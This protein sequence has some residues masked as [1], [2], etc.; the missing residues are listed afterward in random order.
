[1]EYRTIHLTLGELR[2]AS[3]LLAAPEKANLKTA[4]DFRTVRSSLGCRQADKDLGKLNENGLALNIFQMVPTPSGPQPLLLQ[5]DDLL[6]PENEI[7]AR[8]SEKIEA[9][10]NP[11]VE[12]KTEKGL[13]ILQ[14]RAEKLTAYQEL[15]AAFLA[16]RECAILEDSLRL[17]GILCD[18]K[19][20]NILLVRDRM[21]GVVREERTTIPPAQSDLFA[22][23]ADKISDA[24]ILK[25]G[26][27]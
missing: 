26:D 21:T 23:L 7:L 13:E 14:A 5:W 15:V 22:S 19:D 3:F 1:M 4:R 24:L 11:E 10:L 8:L 20:W 6:D 17:L 16:E 27:S 12:P 18:Q 2:V 9:F 25:E